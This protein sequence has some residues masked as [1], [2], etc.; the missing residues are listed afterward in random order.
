[1][2][3]KGVGILKKVERGQSVKGNL[4]AASPIKTTGVKIHGIGNS[5]KEEKVEIRQNSGSKSGSNLTGNMG[6][7]VGQNKAEGRVVSTQDSG[8]IE[9]K[10]NLRN[11]KSVGKPQTTN[12]GTGRI[13]AK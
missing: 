7:G 2:G 12:T 6:R 13:A 5:K 4:R 9:V 3:G 1:M 10:Q 8:R 11:D